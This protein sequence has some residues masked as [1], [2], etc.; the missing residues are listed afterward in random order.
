VTNLD[1]LLEK[2]FTNQFP[3]T[4]LNGDMFNQ[5]QSNDIAW[6]TQSKAKLLTPNFLWSGSV[7]EKF[8]DPRALPVTTED[9][10]LAPYARLHGGEAT[11][12]TRIINDAGLLEP[13]GKWQTT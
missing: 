3:N 2:E 6:F 13:L 5:M 1:S 9:K 12:S 4:V 10:V 7:A 8:F 11:G